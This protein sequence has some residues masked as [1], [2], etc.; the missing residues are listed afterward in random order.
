MKGTENKMSYQGTRSSAKSWLQGIFS[1]LVALNVISL[2]SAIVATNGSGI[3]LSIIGIA[4]DGIMLAAIVKE[5]RVVL[6]ICTIIF[7]IGIVFAVVS[8]V[9]GE[10]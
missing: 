3:G 7:I 8:I 9:A 6:N 10:I 2:I 5:R 4:I 1:A